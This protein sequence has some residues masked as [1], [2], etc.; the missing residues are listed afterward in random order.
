MIMP[1]CNSA[2]RSSFRGTPV[3]TVQAPVSPSDSMVSMRRPSHR[4]AGSDRRA[5][6]AVEHRACSALTPSQPLGA[7]EAGQFAQIVES[8]IS[9]AIPPA[10]AIQQHGRMLHRAACA[11]AVRRACPVGSRSL[12]R[13]SFPVSCA[14]TA[15][16]D[17]R[18]GICKGDRAF[19]MVPVVSPC[20]H[21]P[22]PFAS[23][24]KAFTIGALLVGRAPPPRP[25][26]GRVSIRLHLGA[27]YIGGNDHV[28]GR[29]CRSNR[30]HQYVSVAREFQPSRT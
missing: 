28:V 2:L 22:V 25:P 30:R 23:T 16:K 14:A 11:P 3:A 15:Q 4:A 8:S 20:S 10:A 6:L 26:P 12:K 29:A 18:A 7:C 13:C 9:S 27:C 21:L 5:P 19:Y 1:G 17:D 24:T